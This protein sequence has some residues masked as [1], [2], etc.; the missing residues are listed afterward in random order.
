MKD[1]RVP[2][3]AHLSM[4][5]AEA[6]WGLMAPVGKAAMNSGFD[7][8]SVVSFRVVGGCSA[9]LGGLADRSARAYSRARHCEVGG[10]G[11]ARHR[12]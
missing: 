7:G 3:Q 2:L 8:I 10:S 1:N 11:S 9:L 5:A 4:F 6:I 12:V